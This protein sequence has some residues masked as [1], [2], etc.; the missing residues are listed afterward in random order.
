MARAKRVILDTD[1]GDDIDD[2]WALATC[3]RH[4]GLELTGVTTVLSDTELRA[5]EA[6]HLLEI[7][8]MKDVGVAAGLTPIDMII[9]LLSERCATP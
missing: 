4:P 3:I 1:I 6:R 2:A 9:T 5:G 7:G 8:G